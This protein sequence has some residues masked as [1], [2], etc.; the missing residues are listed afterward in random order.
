MRT[1]N[2]VTVHLNGDHRQIISETEEEAIEL[3]AK[4]MKVKTSNS[5]EDYNAFKDYI[6]PTYRLEAIGCLEKDRLGN[7]F[8]A[9]YKEPMPSALVLKLKEYYDND[10]SVEPLINFW[11]LLMLN[12]DTH[13]RESLFNFAERFHFPITDY[14]YFIAY[15]SVAWKGESDK[16]MALM[17]ASEYIYKKAAGKNTSDIF[18]AK[19]MNPEEFDGKEYELFDSNDFEV[20]EE[21]L[22][23]NVIQ[24]SMVR[25]K[26]AYVDP[27]AYAAM[28]VE[29]RNKLEHDEDE[30][31]Y[32]RIHYTYPEYE[33]MGTLESVY[34]SMITRFNYDVPTFTDFHTRKSTIRLGELQSM[35]REACDNN[36]SNTCSS[37]LHVGAPGYV[38]GFGYGSQ[39]YVIACLVSPANVV[40]VPYDYD[41]E[42]MRTCEYYPYAVCKIDDGKIREVDTRYFEVDY[43]GWEDQALEQELEQ[44]IAINSELNGALLG[45]SDQV[46]LIRERLTLVGSAVN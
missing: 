9:G 3:F 18:V 39:S 35:D 6:D 2:T 13:V 27:Y 22:L 42:K 5:E 41:F 1:G 23:F 26:R 11:K 25:E 8:L 43:K 20:D 28:D 38:Q 33:E 24:D 17:V 4:A 21:E 31:S 40:A 32:Y 19:L 45:E 30:D 14:G 36:P 46:K 10:L 44:I 29:E 7:Y 16:D 15:K 12:P 34:Q 37:G